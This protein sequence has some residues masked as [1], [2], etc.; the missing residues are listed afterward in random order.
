MGQTRGEDGSRGGEEREMSMLLC[1][2]EEIPVAL[3]ALLQKDKHI[4]TP[5]GIIYM[6]A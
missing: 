1:E 3:Y 4:H 6:D 5:K 2:G